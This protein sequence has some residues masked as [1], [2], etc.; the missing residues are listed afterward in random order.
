MA[1]VSTS[2][3]GGLGLMCHM[4]QAQHCRPLGHSGSAWMDFLNDR[5]KMGS[6]KIMV[7]GK[8]V[9][10]RGIHPGFKTEDIRP[11]VGKV[12]FSQVCVCLQGLFTV[13]D[14]VTPPRPGQDGV[15]P[16]DWTAE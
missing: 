13:R 15:S 8:E 10:K 3:G 4:Q 14:G 11:S 7:K 9:S 12:M 16:W 1:D 6:F 5:K 2:I